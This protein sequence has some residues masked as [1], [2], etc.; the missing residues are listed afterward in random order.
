M[1]VFS[2]DIPI[3]AK[4]FCC[5]DINLICLNSTVTLQGQND[6][7]FQCCLV[8]TVLANCPRYKL[9]VISDFYASICFVCNGLHTVPATCANAVHTMGFVPTTCPLACANL[10]TLINLEASH[11][12]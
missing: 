1:T 5:G 10:Y 7:D 11:T 3:F 2:C 4:K 12:K 6:P 9:D 8:Y